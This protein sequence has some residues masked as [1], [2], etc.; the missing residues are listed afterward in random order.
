M[1][2]LYPPLDEYSDYVGTK[3]PDIVGL[4]NSLMQGYSGVTGLLNQQLTDT[5]WMDKFNKAVQ[6][7]DSFNMNHPWIEGSPEQFKEQGWNEDYMMRKIP[8]REQMIPIPTDPT[9][10]YGY[11]TYQ[12][13]IDLLEEILRSRR[14]TT[15]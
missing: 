12:E 5:T 2:L 11:P 13:P 9:G 14:K 6:S 4:L 15:L 3:K 8:Y 7:S 10:S 1:P